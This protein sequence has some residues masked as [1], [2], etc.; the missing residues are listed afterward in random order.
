[1]LIDP[2]MLIEVETDA[3]HPDAR[4]WRPRTQPDA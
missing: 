4:D 1:M 2:A 3:V